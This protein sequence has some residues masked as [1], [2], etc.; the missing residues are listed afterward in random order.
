MRKQQKMSK[1]APMYIYATEMVGTYYSLLGLKNK[2]VLTVCGSGDH[3]LNAYFLGAK[4]V[5]GFDLNKRSEFITRLKIA[6]IMKLSYKEFLK[7]F[8]EHKLN[9]GFSYTLYRKIRENI[10][11]RTKNFFDKLYKQFDFNGQRLTQSRYFRQRDDAFRAY[12]LK[13]INPYLKNE[14]SYLKMRQTL[15]D[16]RFRFIRSDVKDI[17]SKISRERFDIINLSNIPNY[18]AG[19]LEKEGIKDPI[20]KFYDLILLKLRKNLKHNGIIFSYSYSKRF[21]PNRISKQIPPASRLQNIER[22]KAR[23]DFKVRF[24]R[25]EGLNGTGM[26]RINIFQKIRS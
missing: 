13:K 24:I 6:A 4:N 10:D 15:D 8:G 5:V 26:D 7:F 20:M 2:Y 18:F 1:E 22:I 21:Y 16:V 12:P 3:V 11:K 9:V 23:G 25:F 17:C 19:R 14:K